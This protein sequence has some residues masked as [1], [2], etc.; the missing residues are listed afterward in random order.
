MDNLK[1]EHPIVSDHHTKI[2]VE[3]VRAVLTV[4]II[5]TTLMHEDDLKRVINTIHTTMY[6]YKQPPVSVTIHGVISVS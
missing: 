3:T 1:E 6:T 2:A 5:T 4:R